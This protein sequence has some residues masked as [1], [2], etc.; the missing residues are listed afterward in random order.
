MTFTLVVNVSGAVSTLRFD[1][2]E[3][4]KRFILACEPVESIQV[5]ELKE[6]K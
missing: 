4:A 1:S 2:I 5:G 3:D 6:E